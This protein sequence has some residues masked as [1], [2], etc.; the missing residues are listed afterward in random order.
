MSITLSDG[1]TTVVLDPDL[2]WTDENDWSPVRQSVDEGLTGSLIVQSAAVL[3]G[4]PITLQP[5]DDNSAWITR[6]VLDQ[7]RVWGAIPDLQLTL[8]LRG[9]GRIVRCRHQ[10]RPWLTAKPRVHFSDVQPSDQYLIT[11]KFMEI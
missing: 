3:A 11:L 2:Y 1:T 4:R 7:L 6:E 8:T 9:E 10:D 5:E